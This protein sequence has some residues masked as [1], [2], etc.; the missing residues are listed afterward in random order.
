M[1]RIEANDNS[2]TGKMPRQLFRN[3]E[4]SLVW[5]ICLIAFA[6]L[7]PLILL[8]ALAVKIT[9][10]GNIFYIAPRVGYKGKIF[11]LIKFRSMKQNAVKIMKDNKTHIERKDSRLT[12]IG[13]LLRV[14]LDELPQLFN[15]LKGDI[16][17]I[18]PRPVE[19]TFLRF[20]NKL[21]LS[22]LDVLPGITGL[23][24]ICNGR[25]L[26]AYENFVIDIWYI[27][28]HSIL[29]DL[30][31]AILTP[32][33]MLGFKNIGKKLKEQIFKE[34]NLKYPTPPFSLDSADI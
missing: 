1:D 15:I 26:S 4:Y 10:P 33:Y 19:P 12:S 24:A 23:T 21:L 16:T 32:L 31:I 28:H 6:I 14:G 17:L 13:P 5:F 27:Q 25:S 7:L 30:R 22:R 3:I 8:I 20:K 18:G 2:V 11:N 9:S 29:L 34:W